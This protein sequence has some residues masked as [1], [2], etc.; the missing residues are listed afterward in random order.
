VTRAIGK[1]VPD[2]TDRKRA[3]IKN[4]A[5]KNNRL[6]IILLIDSFMIHPIPIYIPS[7]ISYIFLDILYL[8]YIFK[9]DV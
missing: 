4:N 3:I 7:N 9:K 8:C 5:A 2:N 6:P 1:G